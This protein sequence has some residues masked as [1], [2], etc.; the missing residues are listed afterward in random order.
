MVY[1][2]LVP[3]GKG[4]IFADLITTATWFSP[5]EG[6]AHA[7]EL[8]VPSA[9]FL[10]PISRVMAIAGNGRSLRR[11]RPLWNLDLGCV[12]G[13]SPG[14]CTDPGDCT[15]R[16]WK[17]RRSWLRKASALKRSLGLQ[18]WAAFGR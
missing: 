8:V 16:R 17:S 1:E 2:V 5:L 11:Q 9:E 12:S 18:A 13:W 14:A 10:V 3:R 15:I 6:I 7:A 4:V